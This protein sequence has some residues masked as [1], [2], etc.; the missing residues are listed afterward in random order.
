M[1]GH[2]GPG[3]AFG[4]LAI[5]YNCTR[6]ATVRGEVEYSKCIPLNKGVN[7][8]IYFDECFGNLLPSHCA[9]TSMLTHWCNLLTF[10]RRLAKLV[11]ICW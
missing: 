7:N 9:G 1:L 5:L 10:W 4:E 6:T 2:M 8:V 3:K 11:C